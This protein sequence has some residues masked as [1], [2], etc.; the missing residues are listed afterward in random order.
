MFN[1]YTY[2]KQL[3]ENFKEK[4]EEAYK[5]R[6]K[7][8]HKKE[9][10]NLSQNYD[11]RM[12]KFI[13]SMCEKPIILQ[14][15][16]NQDPMNQTFNKKKFIFGEYKTE[17]K[18]LEEME[19]YKNKLK[20]YDQER[21]NIEKKRTLLKI[22]NKRDL[23]LIQPEMRFTSKTQ[24]EKIIDSIKKEDMFKVDFID[25]AL[26]EKLQNNK[27][28]KARKIKEFYNL[29]DKDF[30]NDIDIKKTIK[31]M[32][33]IERD[34][35]TNRYTFKNYMNW[36]NYGIISNNSLSKK[37][38]KQKKEIETNEVLQ[39]INKEENKN[40]VKNEFHLL[41]KD[42]FKTHFKG[43]SQFIEFLDLK[44]KDENKQRFSTLRNGIETNNKKSSLNIAIMLA[45]KEANK[46]TAMRKEL[47][48]KE[49]VKAKNS[50][51]IV[52][53]KKIWQNRPSPIDKIY[54]KEHNKKHLNK[55]QYSMKDLNDILKKKKM[56]MNSKI[57]EQ[58]NN[59][60]SKEFMKKYNSMN[61]FGEVVNIPREYDYEV[62]EN[63]SEIKK[64]KSL[65]GKKKL[66]LDQIIEEKKK[67]NDFKYGQFIK[68]F[69][70]SIFGYRKKNWRKNV[71]EIK[72][73]NK[74]DYIFIDG[75][76][77]P[78]SDIKTISDLIFKK[79]NY[80]NCKK[81]STE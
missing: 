39:T 26:L 49:K 66:L 3:L 72:A 9:L 32:N 76:P 44:E 75:K 10:K 19:L 36:K 18:R 8:R 52:N 25:T 65:E 33:E 30:L 43:S 45:L 20:E 46:N 14:K 29:I 37:R 78:K 71:E 15:G 31:Y 28:S 12:K 4:S 27:F 57:N 51:Y 59:S 5:K 54:L 79:C 1:L 80:Y 23:L 22:K 55:N 16:S 11:N 40:E 34:T 41:V 6:L 69:S 7:L 38:D 63:F 67:E 56:A 50:K 47:L 58:M 35:L 48:A 74:G 2:E 13:Y 62:N 70:R 77:Y 21:K 17:K 73:E 60:I 68:R 81:T 61:F 24:L 53:I 64:D 42:D